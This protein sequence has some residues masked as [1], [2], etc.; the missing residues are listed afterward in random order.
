MKHIFFNKINRTL[1]FNIF[2]SD[3]IQLYIA[4]FY[5]FLSGITA[6][7]SFYLTLNFL[8]KS[9]YLM[10]S[11]LS[12]L[13]LI[14][15]IF[16]LIITFNFLIKTIRFLF[17]AGEDENITTILQ[18]KFLRDQMLNRTSLMSLV[19]EPSL[20]SEKR[21]S[22]FIASAK[23]LRIINKN[24]D[25]INYQDDNLDTFF[26]L[27]CKYSDLSDKKI[28]KMIKKLIQNPKIDMTLKNVHSEDIY[29]FL[30]EEE[31]LINFSRSFPVH[32]EKKYLYSELSKNTHSAFQHKSVYP[33]KR[34]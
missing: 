3:R 15:A 16:L 10:N 5:F 32:Q 13:I 21:Y 30:E 14:T 8:R 22:C 19:S 1:F 9:A 6:S 24:I 34:L 20:Y 31:E 29:L 27:L 2:F 23:F 7:G 26:H 28:H 4:T 17:M 25:T 11:K 33:K 12:I 18:K